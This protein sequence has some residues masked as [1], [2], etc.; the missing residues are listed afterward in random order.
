MNNTITKVK[1]NIEGIY[2]WG[3]GFR[4]KEI[5]NS[6]KEFFGCVNDCGFNHWQCIFDDYGTPNLVSTSGSIYFHPM[7]F[8]TILKC[9][10]E[11][12]I[13]QEIEKICK[14]LISYIGA[15][16]FSIKTQEKVVDFDF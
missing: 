4:S 15:G 12:H 2:D 16:D 1:V 5:F 11:D 9:K 14:Y 3:E 7:G 10:K 6:W 13:I 8:S